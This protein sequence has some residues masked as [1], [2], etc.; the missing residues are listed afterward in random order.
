MDQSKIDWPSFIASMAMILMVCIPLAYAGDD[1]AVFLQHIYD[2]ISRKFGI[3]YLLAAVGSVG[4]LLWLGLSRFGHARLGDG[5][6]EFSQMSWIAMLF[7]AGIGAG[8]MYWCV[9]EW[10]YYY[11]APPFGV[12]P[13]SDAAAEWAS[14]YG[15]FHWGITAWS[16]YCLSAVAIAYPY[17]NRK[18]DILRFSV[19]CN[20]LL[21]GNNHGPLARLIDFLFMIAMIAGA[22]TG[23]GFST[24]MIAECLKWLFGIEHTFQLEV[25]VMAVCVGMFVISVWLGLRSGIKRL[26]DINLLLAIGL[27]LF[28]L[29]AGPTLFLL[30]TSLNGVGLMAQNFIRMNFWTDPFTDSGFVESW[31]VFYWAWWVA[32]APYVG[33]FITRISR[34][35]T[36]RQVIT[37]MLVFGSLGCWVFYMIIGNYSMFLQLN[38]IVDVLGTI[39]A[40]DGSAAIVATLEAIPLAPGVIAVF[41]VM[42]IVFA[43]TTYDSASYTLASSA[44][45]HLS[46]G[47]DPARW[48]RV[49][50]AFALAVMPIT[51]LFVGGLKTIQ[52]MLLI[53]S[54]P[55]LVVGVFMSYSLVRTLQHDMPG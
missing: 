48:H 4:F 32:F 40:I 54:T 44:T 28:I 30:K 43:A 29:F 24:P 6:V 19:G 3:L 52:V 39:K 55:I 25:V 31:T 41:T 45:L 5:E 49:F 34:G 38:G 50:W 42:S 7:C 12:E 53:T 14:T 51:L 33:L 23:L 17:Y 22:A 2:Y 26:S 37:G 21:R 46:A 35:R 36:I 27:L 13:H 9:I 11:D 18:L 16:F 10:T 20:W 47:E 8:L 1:A 15:M